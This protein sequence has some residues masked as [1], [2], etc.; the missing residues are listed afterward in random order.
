MSD[1]YVPT[2]Q[3]KAADKNKK[4]RVVENVPIAFRGFSDYVD[5]EADA[6][7]LKDPHL[8]NLAKTGSQADAIALAI[9]QVVD[10][11]KAGTLDQVAGDVFER[12]DQLL[13]SLDVQRAALAKMIADVKGLAGDPNGATPAIDDRK[14]LKS[15]GP[16]GGPNAKIIRGEPAAF[17][18]PDNK[19][20]A[21]KVF[22]VKED[23][24]T[25]DPEHREDADKG[26]TQEEKGNVPKPVPPKP[27]PAPVVP[28]PPKPVPA[29]T[30][31]TPPKPEPPK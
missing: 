5:Q 10:R 4:Q 20:D 2:P 12:P 1:Q 28:V 24:A 3:S 13:K 25:A 7:G 9:G 14:P 11:I 8:R 18:S 17:L 26:D 27:T 23:A 21:G 22:E 15:A 16:L 31:A 19:D 30:P 6:A 29:P